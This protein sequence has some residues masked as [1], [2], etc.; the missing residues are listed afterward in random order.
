MPD[1]SED[2]VVEPGDD[3]G[4]LIAILLLVMLAGIVFGGGYW[5]GSKS[6]V[7]EKQAQN[8][9]AYGPTLGDCN[10]GEVLVCVETNR[11]HVVTELRR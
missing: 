7:E 9:K 1:N 10:V 5:M 3:E 8:S 11:W 4:W 6:C 2:W